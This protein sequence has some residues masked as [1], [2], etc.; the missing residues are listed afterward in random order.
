MEITDPEVM[1]VGIGFFG[2]FLVGMSTAVMKHH[3]Q[4][5]AGEEKVYGAHSSTSQ[6]LKE[7]RAGTQM[8]EAWRLESMQRSWRRLELIRGQ[9]SWRRPEMMQRSEVTCLL[10]FVG[11]FILDKVSL[12][13]SVSL[14]ISGWP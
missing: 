8:P 6:S 10:N 12:C 7:V 13:S 4:K 3:N 14:C 11:C 1:V 9:R 2:S 5:R